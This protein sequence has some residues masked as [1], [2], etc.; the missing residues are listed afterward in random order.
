M[1]FFFISVNA[2]TP[3]PT[4]AMATA[5]PTASVVMENKQYSLGK[6]VHRH[7]VSNNNDTV[8]PEFLVIYESW[9]RLLIWALSK[10]P[11][12]I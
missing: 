3:A 12:R 10:N 4:S 7:F 8:C 1:G 6:Y 2:T 5:S 9:T 11:S